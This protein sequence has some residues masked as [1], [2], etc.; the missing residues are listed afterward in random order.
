MAGGYPCKIACS[1]TGSQCS[2]AAATRP[3]REQYVRVAIIPWRGHET[4]I[5]NAP[6]LRPGIYTAQTF[7]R[8]FVAR[9]T[10]CL[11]WTLGNYEAAACEEIS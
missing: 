4:D 6:R 9:G 8:L 10:R 7:V 1:P 5:L 3:Q 11:K 2:R